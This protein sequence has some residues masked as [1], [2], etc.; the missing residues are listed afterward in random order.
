MVYT[1]AGA[2]VSRDKAIQRLEAGDYIWV[3]GPRNVQLKLSCGTYEVREQNEE[4]EWGFIRGFDSPNG[5]LAFAEEYVQGEAEHEYYT[6]LGPIVE[7]KPAYADPAEWQ[8]ARVRNRQRFEKALQVL[9]RVEALAENG[10]VSDQRL[11]RM[12]LS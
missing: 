6:L 9:G 1:Y 4:Q 10:T 5:A 2:E 11:A 8:H 7:E 12:L 3:H